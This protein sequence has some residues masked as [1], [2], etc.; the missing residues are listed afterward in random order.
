MLVSTPFTPPARA[1][2]P[3]MFAPT[4]MA[5]SEATMMAG[6]GG[7]GKHADGLR[8]RAYTARYG[9]LS[10]RVMNAIIQARQD[11]EAEDEGL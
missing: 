10:K 11:A 8:T 9:K 4:P 7:G 3:H 5:R 6:S 2:R 1:W